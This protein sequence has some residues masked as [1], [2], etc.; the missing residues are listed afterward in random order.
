[1][2]ILALPRELR[3]EIYTLVLAAD[4]TE[5][6]RT[7]RIRPDVTP[8]VPPPALMLVCKK[9]YRDAQSVYL[10]SLKFVISDEASLESIRQW[11]AKEPNFRTLKDIRTMV[12]T[13]LDPFRTSSPSARQL[14][15]DTQKGMPWPPRRPRVSLIYITGSDTESN[16]AKDRSKSLEFFLSLPCLRHVEI[17]LPTNP[18]RVPSDADKAR[19][20]EK[21][22]YDLDCL[23]AISSLKTVTINKQWKGAI[24]WSWF[25]RCET[26]FKMGNVGNLGEPVRLAFEM[27]QDAHGLKSWLAEGFVDKGL[28]VEVVCIC[29]RE[30]PYGEFDEIIMRIE[31]ERGESRQTVPARNMS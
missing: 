19:R 8:N 15:L 26:A 5:K 1:M 6:L 27:L 9:I 20:R 31:N 13:S 21:R 11:F 25:R 30:M 7:I 2:D 3:D 18:G 16:D 24:R 29:H 23:C 12:F 17:A 10:R 28:N 22:Y 14:H 4:Y